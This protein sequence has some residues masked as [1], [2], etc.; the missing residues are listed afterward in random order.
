MERNGGT[1]KAIVL[2]AGIG[3]LTAAI[4]LRG[5]GLDVEVYERAGELRAAG[6]GLSVMSNAV[7]A[8]DS[9]GAGIDLERRGT[10]LESYHVR[11]GRGRLI[12]EFPFPEIIGRLGVPSVL[13]TRADLQAAL[14]EAAD[15]IPLTLGAAATGFESGEDPR[16]GVRVRFEDGSEAHGDVLIGADG[17]NSVVRRQ[18]VGPE[19]SRDSGYICWLAVVPFS[20]PRFAPGSVTHYWGSGKRFGMVDMGGGRLYW[21]GTK[22]MPAERSADWRGDKSEILAAYAGWADEVQEAIRATPE[23]SVIA[24][25]SRDRAFL[26]RWGRGPVTLLGDAAHPMLTSLGQGSGMAIEDAVVLGRALK[27]AADLPR[28]LRR[29]EDERRERTRAMVAASRGISTFEQ[30]EDPVRRPVR[31]AYFR[32]M[33]ERKLVRT[34]EDS[35]T[36]PLAGPGARTP[37]AA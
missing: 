32:F 4:A 26:E 31:D 15:G 34:L 3:G 12:R 28:A 11:T 8:L 13:I 10:A 37:A 16:D 1:A 23:E 33:P 35:L 30:S 25:P 27:G 14:L 24:V 6:S 18:L 22:N 2:G 7:G 36:F 19:D 20:H 21:W 9:L 29:Y 17:F 5:A